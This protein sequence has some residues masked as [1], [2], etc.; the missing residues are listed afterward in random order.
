MVY[1]LGLGMVSGPEGPECSLTR[2]FRR[3]LENRDPEYRYIKPSSLSPKP[4][5]YFLN[6]GILSVTLSNTP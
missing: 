1:G 5:E 6:I 3:F 4:P 2:G